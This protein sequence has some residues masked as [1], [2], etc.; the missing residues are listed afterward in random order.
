M[1]LFGGLHTYATRLLFYILFYLY[2]Y[3][4]NFN[5]PFNKSLYTSYLLNLLC[6]L[7]FNVN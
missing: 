6:Y 5:C 2:L 7:N 3:T 4:Y 1:Y